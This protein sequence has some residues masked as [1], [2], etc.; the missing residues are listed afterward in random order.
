MK[1][2]TKLIGIGIMGLA[3][4]TGCSNKNVEPA[5]VIKVKNNNSIVV[6]KV[7]K[8]PVNGKQV[9]APEWVCNGGDIP[10]YITAVG[11][12]PESNWGYTFQRNVALTQARAE[13][14]RQLQVKIK[15]M[16]I[17]FM[18]E[19]GNK[20]AGRTV[21]GNLKQITK[22]VST[23]M[24]KDSKLIDTWFAPNNTLFVLVAVPIDKNEIKT[25]TKKVLTSS[26]KNESA[27]W[28]QFQSKEAEKELDQAIEKEFGTK[29]TN[30]NT[31]DVNP[32]ENN[33]EKQ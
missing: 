7:C 28:Q 21:D 5:N 23:A 11:S 30:N 10:G 26:Y 13:I 25:N 6:H 15:D 12:A 3:I 16:I 33:G 14:A 20:K 24:L 1:N 2:T 27:L 4:F 9:Q 32:F 17:N 19:T 31:K 29:N 22:S 8:I 18:D